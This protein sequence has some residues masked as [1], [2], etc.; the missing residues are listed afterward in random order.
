VTDPEP[1]PKDSPLWHHP[2][3][4][5]TAHTSGS[6]PHN[7]R[8]TLEIFSDNIGRAVRGEPLRNLVDKHQG[9]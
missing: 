3:V 4:I 5:V 6:T 9:Y 1:L 7:A 2:K 8:R